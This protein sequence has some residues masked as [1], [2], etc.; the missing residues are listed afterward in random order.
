M[1][2]VYAT[3][4]VPNQDDAS[5]FLTELEQCLKNSMLPQFPNLYV[6]IYIT[7]AKQ[8]QL[9]KPFIAGR[10][11]FVNVFDLMLKTHT[12][13]SVFAFACGPSK[14]V[15]EIWDE[16]SKRTKSGARVDFYHETFEF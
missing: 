14:M 16:S 15:A 10:P 1:K 7:R 11:E 9:N 3:W 2:A 4:V 13:K 6:W 12:E 5:C 8:E